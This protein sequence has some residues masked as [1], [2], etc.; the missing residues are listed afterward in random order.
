MLP[1]ALHLSGNRRLVPVIES[2]RRKLS[3]ASEFWFY[4]LV[5]CSSSSPPVRGYFYPAKTKV[6]ELLLT[7]DESMP[8]Q[9][10]YRCWPIACSFHLRNRMEDFLAKGA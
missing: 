5:W 6:M 2:R 10:V 1:S 9:V 7:I 3:A 8:P 4:A